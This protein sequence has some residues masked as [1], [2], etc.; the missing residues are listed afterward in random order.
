MS[1]INLRWC[2]YYTRRIEK[3]LAK[4]TKLRELIKTYQTYIQADRN[5]L[6]LEMKKM[7]KE[8]NIE[9]GYQMG[10]IEEVDYQVMKQ[11]LEREKN[12]T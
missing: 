6:S 5:R 12:G 7:T 1:K 8:E 2:K 10:F 11:K 3:Y 9:Y 4:I